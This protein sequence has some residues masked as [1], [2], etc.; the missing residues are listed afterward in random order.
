MQF[1]MSILKLYIL[2]KLKMQMAVWRLNV[3]TSWFQLSH[4][5][6][7]TNNWAVCLFTW[8]CRCKLLIGDL[9]W[10]SYK[11]VNVW[12]RRITPMSSTNPLLAF[13]S[14]A[15]RMKYS[16]TCLNRTSLGPT[17]VFGINRCTVYTGYIIHLW[18]LL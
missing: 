18:T 4:I 17:F 11:S 6:C 8:K 7:L 14:C 15:A 13:A 5:I 12:K 1:L 16:D 3:V 9:F 2:M 10:R